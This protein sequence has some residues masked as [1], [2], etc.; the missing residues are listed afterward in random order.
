MK[1][2]SVRIIEQFP[3]L[4]RH[5]GRQSGSHKAVGTQKWQW[6]KKL[7]GAGQ[8][9]PRAL[10]VGR[11]GNRSFFRDVS[12]LVVSL[13]PGERTFKCDQCDAT[14]KRKDTLNV[15]IQVVHDGHKKYKCDLCEKAFVTPSV[16]KSHKKV[17]Y[18]YRFYFI[19]RLYNDVNISRQW[20]LGAGFFTP[21]LNSLLWLVRC[22]R[23][24]FCNITFNVFIYNV[25]MVCGS[26]YH[27]GSIPVLGFV[28]MFS[29]CLGWVPLGTLFSSHSSKGMQIRVTG[30]QI[31]RDRV[32][33]P[34]CAPSPRTG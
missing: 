30:V 26:D 21:L 24:A 15:H 31:S 3:K 5:L 32:C 19:C 17:Q 10:C 2:S 25:F 16:L 23:V 1:N 11:R 28:C 14:F 20:S 9:Q 7:S 22:C 13:C 8:K 33:T 6:L 12:R 34:H 18:I 4:D 29:T 27:C